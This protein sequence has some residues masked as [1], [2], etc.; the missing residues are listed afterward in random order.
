MLFAM[1]ARR[2]R[3]T[4]S[5]ALFALVAA[6]LSA[7]ACDKVPLTAPSESTITLFATAT[8][9][10]PTGSTD[11]VATVIE[12]A[13]TAVQNGTVVSFTTTLGRIEPSEARTQNGKVTVKLTADGRSGLAQVTAFSGGATSEKLE[14]PIGSAAAE[15]VTVRAEPARLPP[16]GG[17]TPIVALVRDL[18]GNPLSGATVAFSASAGTMSSG[19]AADRRQWR[20][21]VHADDVARS[22]PSPPPSGANRARS[23]SRWTARSA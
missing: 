20:G 15:T 8:S 13:G 23:R 14:L 19:V 22:R 18:A 10:S 9:V 11:I 4:L 17:S 21:T 5:R 6:G 12:E 1:I 2:L 7:T 16:G 3:P